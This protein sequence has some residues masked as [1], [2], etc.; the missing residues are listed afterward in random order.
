MIWFTRLTFY[1]FLLNGL[2]LQLLAENPGHAGKSAAYPPT[3]RDA[4]KITQVTIY[5]DRALVTREL[6]VPAGEASQIVTIDGIPES[7]IPDSV[8]AEIV[9][10]GTVRA[11]QVSRE[12]QEPAGTEEFGKLEVE[13]K[14]LQSRSADLKMK[15]DYLQE[16]QKTLSSLIQFSAESAQTDLNRGVIN[17]EELKELTLF[18]MEKRSELSEQRHQLAADRKVVTDAIDELAD[19][20]DQLDEY[21]GDIQYEARIFLDAAPGSEVVIRLKYQVEG[22]S[23][24]P[25]YN[26]RANSATSRLGLRIGAEI[27]QATGESWENVQLVLSAASP[28]SEAARPVLTP[29]RVTSISADGQRERLTRH[30]SDPLIEDEGHAQDFDKEL[31]RLTNLLRQNRQV[32]SATSARSERDIQLNRFAGQLQQIELEARTRTLRSMA[33]DLN[34]D[35]FSQTYS[36]QRPVTLDSRNDLQL[37]LIVDAELDARLYHVATPLLNSFAYRQAEI[38]NTFDFG[39]LSGPAAIYLDDRFVGQLEIPATA[40]GQKLTLGLGPDPQVRTR[41]ELMDKKDKIQG[42]NRQIRF[43]YRLV[44]GNMK[45]S[46]IE[47]RLLDRIPVATESEQI[48]VQFESLD[49]ELSED[50]TYQRTLRPQGIVRWDLDIPADKIGAEAIDVFYSSTLEF[51]RN[52]IPATKHSIEEILADYEESI[53][54]GA[55]GGMGGG[56]F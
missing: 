23:W 51:D 27:Q 30:G 38:T 12:F 5:R 31:A 44:V 56:F 50:G 13:L 2:T 34:D 39:L 32:G 6:K 35:L 40:K 14:E 8:F 55:G 26:V 19:R 49:R 52:K 3:L 36:L 48:S 29:L 1:L 46:P 4:G 16:N 47:L 43:D 45:D 21:R 54:R 37:I 25:T 42:G 9:G 41:R 15:W 7:V 53:S 24:S 22:C 20:M 11:V 10:E 33:I 18:A 28:M 17:A